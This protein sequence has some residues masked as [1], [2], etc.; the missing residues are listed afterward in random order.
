[1]VRRNTLNYPRL[2]LAI[3]KR[4]VKLAVNRNYLR[5]VIRESFR[6][7][8]SLFGGVDVVVFIKK[9]WQE[10]DKAILQ[11]ELRRQWQQLSANSK[12]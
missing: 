3:A 11:E 6:H 12:K 10:S 5:R 9:T 4:C 1:V 8:Q 2:G 7:Q